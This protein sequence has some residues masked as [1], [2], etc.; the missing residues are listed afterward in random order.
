MN[1]KCK[2]C[3]TKLRKNDTVCMRC[4][5]KVERKDEITF[6]FPTN[7]IEETQ[8]IAADEKAVNYDQIHMDLEKKFNQLLGPE[9][10]D[11]EEKYILKTIYNE[12]L[13]PY[14][15]EE[16]KE[17]LFNEPRLTN[18]DIAVNYDTWQEFRNIKKL[19][20]CL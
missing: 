15:E 13:G 7:E 9:I 8:T 17:K 11:L 2:N 18:S 16:L 12:I 6:S 1:D 5:A 14:T 4:G 10:V 19:K 3:G 20:K